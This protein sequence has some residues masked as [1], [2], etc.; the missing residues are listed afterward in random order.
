MHISIYLYKTRFILQIFK[1]NY[2]LVLNIF[3]A[4]TVID[5]LG[6]LMGFLMSLYFGK[7]MR[8]LL[9]NHNNKN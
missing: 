2:E 5:L 6:R 4:Q 9:N 7:L 1:P 8:I 3:K